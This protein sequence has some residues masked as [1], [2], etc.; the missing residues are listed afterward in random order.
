MRMESGDLAGAL[1]D[2][3]SLIDRAEQ[4]DD[5]PRE[6]RGRLARARISYLAEP[7]TVGAFQP[8]VDEALE[9]FGALG[10]DAGLADAWTVASTTDHAAL[11]WGRV[12][13]SLGRMLEHAERV[14][15]RLLADE[16]NA[17]LTAAYL[18]G[19][20]P[21]DEAI[22]WYEAHPSEHPF[23]LANVG[24]LEAMRGNISKAR[25]LYGTAIERGKERGQLLLAASAT[26][27]AA[28]AELAAGDPALAAEIAL[29]GV[30]ELEALGEQ[31]WLSTV[32]GLAAEALYRLGR[33]EEAW[34]LTDKAEDAGAADDVIT[35]MLIRQ[36][37]G[38]IL[39][40][41][42]QHEAAERLVAEAVE[43]C[44]P[45]DALEVKA[46]AHRDLAIVLVAANKRSEALEALAQAQK[47]YE[48]KGHT[49]GVARMEE[50][51]AE[52]IAT[53]PA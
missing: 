32:A 15:D 50:L 44:K 42:G 21:V 52:V 12:Q 4:S 8:L 5:R 11:R 9:L 51:R 23:F 19:P 16:A 30:A 10:D 45:T 48:E 47:L 35:Q 29:G 7:A 24:Q 18:Y 34:H 3:D 13:E 37:R 46:D 1:R 39:S 25:E 41:R 31:G 22:S 6:L 14:G 53:L 27:E 40:R 49:A 26:M 20:T 38:K 28:D 33:D 36:V 17:R 2:A 43:W